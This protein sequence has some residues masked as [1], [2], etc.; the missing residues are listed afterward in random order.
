MD[1]G[2]PRPSR[3]RRAR[4]GACPLAIAL[5]LTLTITLAITGARLAAHAQPAVQTAPA[6]QDAPQVTFRTAT[7]LV[8]QTVSVTDRAGRPIEG[9][10]APD[11]VVTEDGVPQELA[12][13]EFQRLQNDPLPTLAATASTARAPAP[14]A[15]LVAGAPPATIAAAPS[16]G[17]TYRDKRL[18]VLYFDTSSL[19]QAEQ[20]RAYQHALTFV[21]GR[22]T[23]SDLVA[24][25]AFKDG[26]VRVRSDFTDNRAQLVETLQTL[27]YGDDLDGDGIPDRTDGGTAFGQNDAEFSLFNT[28]RQ[29]AALQMAVSMLRALPEQKTLIYFSTGVRLNGTDNQ[30]QLRATINAAL[31]ANT[32]L[33]PVDARGLVALAPMGDATQR[34]P[35]G[36]SLFTGQMAEN[37]TSSF[38]RSQD[39]LYG[40]AKDTGG[41]AT[42][43][44]N[45]LARGIVTAAHQVTSYYVL[46]YYTTHEAKDGKF[47]RVKVALAGGRAGTLAYREGYYGEKTWA[48]FTEADRET[49][50]EDAMRQGDPIT[51]IP[52]AV[53]VNYFQ[54]NRA[55]Y[56][57]PVTVKI[58]GSELTLAQRKGAVRTRIDVIG[59]IK[60]DYGIT[61]KNVRDK[62]DIRLTAETAAQIVA[63]P[64]LYETGFTLLPGKY[65]IKLLTR[66][67]E[68]GRIG[69]YQTPFT[70]PN[71]D[72]EQQRVAISSVVLSS[73][74]VALDAALFTV[75]G[76]LQAA[77]LATNPLVHDG[78]RLVPSVTRVFSQSRDLSVYLQAYQRQATTMRP[79][80]AFATFYQDG[81]Q[82]FES[83]PLAVADGW[84]P[85][86]KAIP[87]RLDVPLAGFAPG[88]YE[89]QITVLDPE[90]QHAAFW[91]API[92]VVP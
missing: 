44:D 67:V 23:A 56:F 32:T 10:T 31:R 42:F 87:L 13:V 57:T 7:R 22:L 15:P 33:N 16:G 51:E 78:E 59:E 69:T 34:S 1:T 83:T 43:D 37:L 4:T 49:Q 88:R 89:C 6:V 82:V 45:D 66:D 28:D 81:V 36:M 14:A 47:R 77:A 50:L 75:E 62:L 71:L 12:F 29:L 72:K 19:G 63:R 8:V 2:L 38:Q 61:A 64:V 84:N 11:F 92:A 54:L 58:P 9:L 26:T 35:G 24:V 21:T 91:R 18:L 48:H 17:I 41:I 79:L 30:A 52:M 27:L 46:G 5:A 53:E 76:K 85:T 60:D 20:I 3:R 25:L 39:T 74:R 80:V 55:E 65:V 86:S 90:A 73:Q 40:L 68:T 70:I